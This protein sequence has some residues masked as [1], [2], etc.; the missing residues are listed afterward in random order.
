LARGFRARGGRVH[1]ADASGARGS[2]G[3]SEIGGDSLNRFL[4]LGKLELRAQARGAVLLLL[5]ILLLGAP[6]GAHQDKQEAEKG[7]ALPE[8]STLRVTRDVRLRKGNHL[9][10]AVGKDGRDGVLLCEGLTGVT[11]DLRGITLRGAPPQ[12]PLDECRGWGILL[13]GCDDVRILGG[14]LGGYQACIVAQDCTNLRIEGVRFDGWYGMHLSSTVSAEKEEDWLWPHE[15]DDG[16]WLAR[17]GGAISLTD[18]ANATVSGCRGRHGQNGILLTRASGAQIYDNDF[19]FLSGWGVAMYRSSHNVV[20]RNLLDY[21]VRG[22]SHG[23]YWRGQDS[24]AILMFERCSDNVIALNSATHSGDGIFLY[25]GNDI[26]EGKA[27]AGGEKEPGGS[28]RNLFWR[29]DLS[30][31]VAN[32]IEATFSTGNRAFENILRG[33]HQHG[34]WAGYSHGMAIV[35]NTLEGTLGGG[36]TIEHGQECLIARNVIHHNE[37]GVELYW[38]EDP[39]FVG[40]PFGQHFDTSSRGHWIY[41]NSF[42][43]NDFDLA[44]EKTG[45]LVFGENVFA[46]HAGELSLKGL[47]SAVDPKEDAHQLG[48]RLK[49]L[50]GW[51]PS[52]HILESSLQDWDGELHPALAAA[53]AFEPPKLPGTQKAFDPNAQNA[54]DAR[55]GLDTIVM[56]EWGPWDFRSGEPRPAQRVPGGL[57]A[58]VKWEATWFSWKDGPDPRG[59]SEALEAWRRLA[60]PETLGI[61]RVT[62]TVTSW[63]SPWGGD[64]QVQAQIGESRFGLI[65][66]ARAAIEAGKY[67]LS[68][69]SDDGVRVWV[70]GQ[71]ALENWTWHAPT[72]NEV[73]ITLSA[74]EH[75]LRLEYFQIDGASALAVD[76][77]RVGGP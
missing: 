19:S 12:T 42:A 69:V 46:A 32:G 44:I 37:T 47:E 36:I 43:E 49:G 14:T 27:F 54:P 75:D 35:D 34:I 11:L 1:A 63:F 30:Y 8:G 18:C 59:A 29:N 24:A 40:G 50:G 4:E 68:V 23:V 71:V 16:Q 66:T 33:C 56:G 2:G 22:Y 64:A 28:D 60:A 53:F 25:A 51:L 65:A 58:G 55:R 76:L 38:D 67:R 10:P 70:D 20:C 48:E 26:V 39:Q 74:G 7:A 6:G 52:G 31:A 5:G 3:A 57:L 17:Y 72:K 41:K 13:K 62:A 15:N 77:E 45:G 73:E 21:C 9:R 61:T